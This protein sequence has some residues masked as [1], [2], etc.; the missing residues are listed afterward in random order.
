M[1]DSDPLTRAAAALEGLG[2]SDTNC[3]IVGG[4]VAARLGR[5][6]LPA[7]WLARREALPGWAFGGS[8]L[9]D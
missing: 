2:D 6:G 3:A 5:G 7:D 4:I 9:L 1:I 8:E